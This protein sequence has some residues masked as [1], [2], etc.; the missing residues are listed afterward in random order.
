LVFPPP[1]LERGKAS[2]GGKEFLCHIIDPLM[3]RS[4][5]LGQRVFVKAQALLQRDAI[6]RP[7]ATTSIV[8]LIAA[9]Q[10]PHV[11]RTDD[12][13]ISYNRGWCREFNSNESEHLGLSCMRAAANY[14]PGF[15]VG[16]T[17]RISDGTFANLL[18]YNGTIAIL[19]KM[20]G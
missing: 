18:K 9:S 14:V 16:E 6:V 20:A 4:P 1:L 19:R 12:V 13:H 15:D 5:A 7:L 11:C 17:L 3:I 10:P 2:V 8:L